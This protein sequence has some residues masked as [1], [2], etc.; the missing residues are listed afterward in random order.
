MA[1]PGLGKSEP[2]DCFFL[3]RDFAVRIVSV[4]RVQAVY[5]CLGAKPAKFEVCN[6]N[7][8][9]ECH[10]TNHSLT[11]LG[12]IFP[13]TALPL[14]KSKLISYPLGT[15]DQERIAFM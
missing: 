2:S 15:H 1:E 8:E 12:P 3:V 14:R 4:E 7:S 10:I 13:S 5:I 6:Q 11:E 9:T